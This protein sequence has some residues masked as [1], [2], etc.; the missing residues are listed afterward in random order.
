MSSRFPISLVLKEVDV[1]CEFAVKPCDLACL[2]R[3]IG[4][5]RMPSVLFS[6]DPI[7]THAA[8]W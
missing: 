6:I 7:T 3:I 2:D 8:T 1:F 5:I 4:A